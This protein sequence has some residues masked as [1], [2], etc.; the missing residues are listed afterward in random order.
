VDVP[1]L[2]RPDFNALV[3]ILTDPHP[4]RFLSEGERQR[5]QEC[6]DSIIEAR[7]AGERAA[8]EHWVW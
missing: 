8:M 1:E 2:E 5:H 6:V 7:R 4:E 3:A